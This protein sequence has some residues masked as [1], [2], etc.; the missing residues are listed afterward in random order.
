MQEET[1]GRFQETDRRSRE[2][3]RR[4]AEVARLFAETHDFINR[5]AHIAEAHEQR[6]DNLEKR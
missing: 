2:T 4:F 3:D 5:L 6:L 1:D